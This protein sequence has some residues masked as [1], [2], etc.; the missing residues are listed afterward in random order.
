M[1]GDT[2]VHVWSR[3]PQSSYT[4]AVCRC[5]SKRLAVGCRNRSWG[6]A[7]W[8]TWS[9]SQGRKIKGLRRRGERA[10][11]EMYTER[12]RGEV[13]KEQ[14]PPSG[15]AIFTTR[16]PNVCSP[17]MRLHRIRLLTSEP[18]LAPDAVHEVWPHR[19][20]RHGPR[21]PSLAARQWPLW[22]PCGQA[23]PRSQSH[24]GVRSH[25]R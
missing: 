7:G 12:D 3:R 16:Y 4:G 10:V 5:P 20:L 25:D 21:V 18:D 14:Q 2:V 22:R 15:V 17:C 8:R 24:A 1:L 13:S 19:R 6:A 9:Y 11:S 23:S